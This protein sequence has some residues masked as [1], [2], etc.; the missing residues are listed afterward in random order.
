MIVARYKYDEL[1]KK[2]RRIDIIK[3]EVFRDMERL[4]YKYAEGKDAVATPTGDTIAADTTEKLDGAI[5]ARHLAYR[6]A[7]LRTFVR[8]SLAEETR[9]RAN[10][11]KDTDAVLTYIFNLPLGFADA[12][13]QSLAELIH[14]YLVWGILRD[15]YASIGSEQASVY[16][17]EL[18][19]LEEEIDSLLR[20]PSRT[21]RPMQPFG[22]AHRGGDFI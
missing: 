9:V 14:R 16:D 3:E 6:D 18:S 19:A 7:K 20:T 2:I 21:K 12:V 10:D 22:P 5:A 11:V 4:S 15:W 13:L 17:A 1:P 8:H